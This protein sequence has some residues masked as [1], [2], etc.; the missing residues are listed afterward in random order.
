MTNE[1]H[2]LKVGQIVKVKHDIVEG[3]KKQRKL[4]AT[5][6]SDVTIGATGHY[7]VL[8]VSNKVGTFSVDVNSVII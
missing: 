4:I 7:P 8:I 1:S 3:N 6:L 5:A 2:G